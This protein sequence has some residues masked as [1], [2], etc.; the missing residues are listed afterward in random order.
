M[1]KTI[2]NIKDWEVVCLNTLKESLLEVNEYSVI[3]KFTRRGYLKMKDFLDPRN[4]V[5]VI[6]KVTKKIYNYSNLIDGKK[7][8]IDNALTEAIKYGC[9][10]EYMELFYKLYPEDE[11]E[12]FVL[13]CDGRGF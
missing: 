2:Q 1:T 7:I 9:Q 5:D 12:G 11:F 4:G 13:A 3:E 8:N 6:S 10:K